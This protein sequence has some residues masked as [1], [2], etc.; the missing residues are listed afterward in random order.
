MQTI[1]GGCEGFVLCPGQRVV[2]GQGN[3]RMSP[4]VPASHAAFDRFGRA[5]TDDWRRAQND[6]SE[7]R[8]R[9]EVFHS[10]IWDAV[11]GPLWDSVHY[12][13]AP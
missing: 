4:A 13:K 5:F 8:Y 10:T 3:A 11:S 2:V 7:G 9:I 1:G 12:R 6:Q